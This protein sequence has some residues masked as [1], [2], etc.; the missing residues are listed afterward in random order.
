[1]N[2]VTVALLS[3]VWLA[4]AYQVYGRVIAR[5][6]IKPDDSRPTP[7][8]R[9]NDGVDYYPAQ[10]LVLF[11]HHFASIAGAG[12]IIGPVM[13]AAAFGWGPSALWILIGVVLI[14]AVHDYTTL[15]VSVRHD[16]ASIPEITQSVVGKSARF[17]FLVFVWI[18]L[19]FVIAV[20]AIAAAK[21]F[22][23]DPRIVIPAFGLIPLAIL[24]SVLV[25]RL[26]LPIWIGTL[27]ALGL[28]ILLFKAGMDIPVILPF[29]RDMALQIWIGVLM[30]YSLVAAVLPVW[31]LLQPRDYL[32]YWILAA[33]MAV[34]FTG[35]FLT[36]RPIVAPFAI[37]WVSK[38]QGPMWPMLF[39]LI[40]CGAISGFH[41][42]VSSG[43]T[44]KQLDRESHGRPVA[45]GA[46]IAEGAL[47]MLALLAVTAGLS[48]SQADPGSALATPSL[49][50]FLGKNGG[51]PIAAF[52][53]GFGVFTEPLLGA[54]G[55]LFGMTMLNAFVLT[56]LD[57][58]V[59]LARFITSELAGSVVGPL[60]NRHV[61]AFLVVI[62]AYGLAS[63]GSEQ[64]L[65][66]MFGAANQLVAALAMIVVT[67]YFSQKGKSRGYTL[68]PAI[69]MLL[70]TCGAL[71]WK[72]YA[73]L[74]A[75]VPNYALIIAAIVLLGLAVYVGLSGFKAIKRF[76][77]S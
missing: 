10:P 28:L 24:F 37:G 8:H 23:A 66:P 9:M 35:L 74:T 14:G 59:R 34:G 56:T 75:D 25:H 48:F 22:V 36:H 77:N 17:L 70:T 62:V 27:A 49:Q 29:E 11:G 50:E 52:A 1:M 65:W 26:G 7:A 4:V 68:V 2:S 67:A 18:T 60:K 39:I 54:A 13:A 72:G 61:S 47:A 31:I 38:T 41:S 6:L 42:L 21:S 5:K 16:S 46:M 58:S 71:I 32:A 3:I 20:F 45:F 40:A 76:G 55:A 63:S 43:T 69:F 30:L 33:G 12:P 44:A 57:T 53:T 64:A 19:I 15:M 51:G 73:E